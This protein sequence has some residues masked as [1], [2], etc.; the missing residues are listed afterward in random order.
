MFNVAR[1][2]FGS[3]KNQLL[4]ANQ[5]VAAPRRTSH[6]PLL[7][8]EPAAGGMGR[9]TPAQRREEP[10]RNEVT[11]L[12]DKEFHRRLNDWWSSAPASWGRHWRPVVQEMGVLKDNLQRLTREEKK[13]G[14]LYFTRGKDGR[15]MQANLYTK[16]NV[17]ETGEVTVAMLEERMRACPLLAAGSIMVPVKRAGGHASEYNVFCRTVLNFSLVVGFS[18]HGDKLHKKALSAAAGAKEPALSAAAGAKEPA[19]SAA[20]G[21]IARVIQ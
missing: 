16:G 3:T 7:L 13:D 9:K 5:A 8:C 21:L 12:E 11:R 18:I 10:F 17:G 14:A 2:H 4:A 1:S 6:P 19:R 15:V 20:A